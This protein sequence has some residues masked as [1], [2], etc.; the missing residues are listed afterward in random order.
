MLVDDQGQLTGVFTDSDLA[1]L[2]EQRRDDAIDRPIREVMTRNPCSVPAGAMLTDAV[3]I[4]AERKISELPVIDA[5]TRRSVCST[6][7][8]SWL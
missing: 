2:F 5:R 3:S 1:R 7:P 6:S 8:T 4:L